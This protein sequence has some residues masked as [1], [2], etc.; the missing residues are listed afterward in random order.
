MREVDIKEYWPVVVRD[1][2]EF[3]KLSQAENPE[4]TTLWSEAGNVFDDQ[5]ITTAT[6][7]GV[8]RW[9]K[10]LGITPKANYTLED[11]RF[12]ILVRLGEQLPYTT[13]VFKQL[14]SQ[15]CGKDGYVLTIDHN[16]YSV[17]ILVE[18]KS[19]NM[20][21]EVQGLSEK[22]LPA[23]L[24]IAIRIRYNQHETLKR[25]THQ[26]LRALTHDGVRNEVID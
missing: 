9:E 26:D 6:L 24:T 3:D 7:N 16:L 14:L 17:D 13:P 18:L 19:K 2:R 1:I 21:S 12:A 5:F 8:M 22:M 11:R 20:V 4:I 25:F 15:L 10:I 23:N